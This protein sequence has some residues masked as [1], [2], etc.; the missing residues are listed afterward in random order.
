M[1]VALSSNS[2][3]AIRKGATWGTAV[4]LT[5]GHRVPFR[6]AAFDGQPGLLPDE[7]VVET[8]ERNPSD[9][10]EVRAA[11]D[12][13]AYTDYRQRL[14]LWAIMMG[15]AGTPATV[16]ASVAFKHTLLW[17]PDIQ[18]KFFTYG[19]HGDVGS[20]KGL[21]VASAKPNTLRLAGA[22]GG[23]LEETWGLLG[24]VVTR[25][26]TPSGWTYTTDPMGGAARHV[27]HRLGTLRINAGAGGALGSSDAMALCRG[28]E[29]NLNR[30]LSMDFG[31]N[32]ASIEPAPD[33]FADLT[34]KLDFYG[35]TEALY[36]LLRNA[37]EAR[38][39]MKADY[40][41]DSGIKIGASATNNYLFNLYMPSM[42]I[43]DAPLPI[44]GPGRTPFSVEFALHK[45]AAVPTGF[46]SGY[47]EAL[48][49]EFQNE[50]SADIL[51]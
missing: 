48:V 27:L 46:P 39:L 15:T 33:G 6:S 21:K 5:T 9:I 14:L 1:P 34:L 20:S 40:L 28:F 31:A 10:I 18:G 44:Q 24:A 12:L 19:R 42:V 49:V 26:E 16:E 30:N 37:Q 36:D 7:T 17:T 47:D 41:F 35:A 2:K 29:L 13:A 8:A 22:V 45:A 25:G 32:L 51:A 23:R 11:G 43:Q 38:T 50:L 4:A 3:V